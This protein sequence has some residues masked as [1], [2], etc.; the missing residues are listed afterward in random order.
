M[1]SRRGRI[2]GKLGSD[3]RKWEVRK[4]GGRKREREK[5]RERERERENI[6][7]KYILI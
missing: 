5:E 3:V 1:R 4:E 7:S 6:I 2:R